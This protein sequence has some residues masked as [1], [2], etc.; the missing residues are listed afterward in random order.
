MSSNRPPLSADRRRWQ[1][2]ISL[3]ELVISIVIISVGLAGLLATFSQGVRGSAD[4]LVHK[5][6]LAIA[7]EMLEEIM[8]KP[9][10]ASANVG[11]ATACARNTFNDIDDYNNYSNTAA[12][13]VCDIDGNVV[14]GL[15]GYLV[16]VTVV[17]GVLNGVTAKNITVNVTRAGNVLSL[18]GWRTGWAL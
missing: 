9:Y 15:A 7:E 3:V 17:D 8:L 1:R 16:T 14:A 6:M 2:G 18:N 5:Q 13:G 12:G 10:A 11:G 4:P